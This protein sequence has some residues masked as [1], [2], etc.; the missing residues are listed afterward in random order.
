M[1]ESFTEEFVPIQLFYDG[2]GKVLL[3]A[4]EGQNED[5]SYLV[6][7]SID[8]ERLRSDKISSAIV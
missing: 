7:Y 5:S 1:P 3:V 6:T 8:I 4:K 2:N